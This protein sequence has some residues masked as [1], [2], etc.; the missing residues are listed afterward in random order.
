MQTNNFNKPPY[1]VFNFLKARSNFRNWLQRSLFLFFA[2][3][4]TACGGGG[5]D[6]SRDPTNPVDPNPQP[7]TLNITLTIANADTGEA[8]NQLSSDSPLSVTATV[9]DSNGDPVPDQLVTYNFNIP[10]LATFSPASGTALTNAQ[11]QSVIGINVGTVEGDGLITAQLQTGESRQIGFSSAGDLNDGVKTIT[12]SIVSQITGDADNSL[13]LDNPLTIN[14]LVLA[15]DDTPVADELITFTFNQQGLAR[16]VPEAGTALSQ[17]NGTANINLEVGADAGAG[18][19]VATLASGETAQIGFTSAGGS[20]VVD[21]PNF[22]LDL[23]IADLG[24]GEARNELSKDTPLRITTVLTDINGDPVVDQ[25]VTYSLSNA[26]LAVFEPENGETLTDENGVSTIILGVGTVSGDGLVTATIPTGESGQIGFSSAGDADPGAKTVTLQIVDAATGE[27]D[28]TV[29]PDNPLT[30]RA[31]VVNGSGVPLNDELIQF[32]VTDDTLAAFEPASGTALTDPMGN[33]NIGL[34]AGQNAGAGL[35]IATL[36][37]GETAEIGFNSTGG[38][39]VVEPPDFTIEMTISELISGDPGNRVSADTPLLIT[40]TVTDITGA[41][42]VDQL[43]TYTFS[44]DTLAI[45][46]PIAGETLTDPQGVSRITVRVGTVAGDGLVFATLPTG[47]Q[48]QIGFSS[49][50]DQGNQGKEMALSI[51]S[52]ASGEADND[53]SSANPLTVRAQVVTSSGEPV[54]DELITFTLSDDNLAFFNP[55]SGTALTDSTGLA[56]IDLLVGLQAGA[57]KIFA[58]LES[59]EAAEIGFNSAGDGQGAGDPPATLDFFTSSLVLASSGSDQVELIALVKDEDNIL[60]EGIDVQFSSDSGELSIIQGTTLADG[61]ARALLTS[62]NNPENRTI[63][64]TAATGDLVQRLTIDVTGTVVNINAPNSVILNDTGLITIIVANSD[65]VGIPN[66]TVTL[67]STVEGALT[68]S[69]ANTD[70]T[71]QLIVDYNAVQ[72]GVDTITVSA[73]NAISTQEIVVQ[74]D[75]FGF[76]RTTT[77]EVPL[78]TQEAITITWLKDNVPFE[79]GDVTFT[80][81]RGTLSTSTGTT[82]ANGQVTIN[83]ESTT[84]GNTIISATGVD[85]DGEEVSARIEFEY[86]ATQVDSIIVSAS[87][88]SIGPGGQKSTVTAVVRDQIGNLVKGVTIGFTADDVSGGDIFPPT[89][90][91]DRNGLASTVFTSNTVTSEDAVVITASHEPSGNAASADITVADRALFI[92]IG[93]GNAIESPDSSSYLKRFSLFV[94]DANSNPVSNVELTVSGTPVR[95]DDILD[96]GDPDAVPPVP[97]TSRNAFFKGYWVEL[98]SPEAFEFW[99]AV[100]VTGCP[101]EDWDS[102]GILDEGED[103]NGDGNLTPG[104]I[105]AIDG[106]VTTDQNGQAEIVLRYPKTFG[107]WV[108]VNIIASTPVA[109][110]ENRVSQYHRLG[111]SAEDA[112]VESSPPNVNPFGVGDSCDN[113]L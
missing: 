35:V 109:G 81:T 38:N 19:V 29:S 26:D 107:A 80:T 40:A 64:V 24:S 9:T 95:F 83:A 4:I 39:V 63:T 31:Y 47:E 66:Q 15:S 13:T 49:A 48:A 34:R 52:T 85:N 57:G 46:D 23:G 111:V 54:V 27:E 68:V 76:T 58:T 36:T 99:G 65:S 2:F 94:T 28:N 100:T 96:P 84:A 90:V 62:Q 42:V 78:N 101:N 70:E 75:V 53:L 44:N 41:P 25:L 8:S 79:G 77:T 50:G 113:T 106:N 45:F 59:G 32:T 18:I 21:P 69:T 3:L 22:T 5:G 87:P 61:T 91:T 108:T 16:F 71:G 67:S 14:A 73:L 98:P 88:N 43:V 51:V 37:T 112:T 1:H 110:S 103:V 20:V 86:I 93:T 74:E 82:D 92:S 6:I 102:D 72:S 55:P 11:G 60:M 105:V 89:A 104:N 17:P 33:A 12:L 56:T 10:D 30:V 7:T 97:A